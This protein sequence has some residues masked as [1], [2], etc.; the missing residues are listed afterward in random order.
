MYKN[1]LEKVLLS[2]G[3]AVRT[4]MADRVPIQC[5]IPPHMLEEIAKK[6]DAKQKEWALKTMTISEKLRGRREA[7]AEVYV[8]T[9]VGMKFRS[10]YDA[11]NGY[12]LPGELVRKEGD[13]D[14]TDVAVNEAYDG[15][16]ATYDLYYDALSATLLMTGVCVWT[17]ACIMPWIMITHSGTGARWSTET[18]ME[19]SSSASQN[20]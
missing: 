7:F 8:A 6:G 17:Q 9:P 2:K 19:N 5:I 13:P 10:V 4:E 12:D 18:V 15:A 16:G 14:S 20:Q 11:K 1:K 3:G